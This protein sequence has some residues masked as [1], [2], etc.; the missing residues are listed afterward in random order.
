[1]DGNDVA[2]VS[3]IAEQAPRG[4]D[5]GIR[6]GVFA[7]SEIEKFLLKCFKLVAFAI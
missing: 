6:L 5:P 1:M 4:D 2:A 3:E 7:C